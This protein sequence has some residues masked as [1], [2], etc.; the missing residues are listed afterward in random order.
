MSASDEKHPKTLDK[1]SPTHARVEK[2]LAGTPLDG[3]V[4][5]LFQLSWGRARDL[6]KRGKILV[7]GVVVTVGTT[8]MKEGAEIELR[9]H[10]SRIDNA[11]LPPNA[12][13]HVDAHIVVVDKPSG[14]PTL[15]FDP[16]GMGASIAKRGG[17]GGA[18]GLEKNDDEGPTLVERVRIALAR[19]EKTK[20]PPRELGVVHRLDKETSGLIVF[21]RSWLAKKTLS[22][23]FRFRHVHRR[24]LALVNGVMPRDV[25]TIESHFVPDRGDGLRGSVEKRHGR[26]H[27]VGS[28]RV[29]RA[30]THVE[31]V[32]RFDHANLRATLVSCK[33][34]TGRTHQI[35]IHLAE[36]GHPIVGERVYTRGM[37]MQ[38]IAAP[39]VMLHASELGFVHPR[40]FGEAAAAE[41]A[42]QLEHDAFGGEDDDDG[43]D[44]DGAS[45]AYDNEREMTHWKS[46]LPADMALAVTAL[47]A[48]EAPASGRKAKR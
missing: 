27:P 33:L 44:V 10:A 29:Q 11:A 42:S 24:Y 20:G 36:A 39:R 13:V 8:R 1:A 26:N 17:S 41:E 22:Q 18:A 21:T 7:D 9:L 16:R 23:A 35:R 4:R 32:E 40:L 38:V 5:A 34:E 2:E 12:I 19:R 30:V 14:I 6:V 45:E 48:G 46:E 28:E 37:T 43:E 3:V 31:V 15:P 25:M 47:R